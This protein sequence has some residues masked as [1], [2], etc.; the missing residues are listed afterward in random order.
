ML[1]LTNSPYLLPY[2][3]EEYSDRSRDYIK[4]FIKDP[5]FQKIVDLLKQGTYPNDQFVIN[6][7]KEVYTI[8]AHAVAAVRLIE[9]GPLEGHVVVLNSWGNFEIHKPEEYVDNIRYLLVSKS[10]D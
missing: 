4:E 6:A 7:L 2:D 1:I 8:P 3:I 5:G 9:D 10:T